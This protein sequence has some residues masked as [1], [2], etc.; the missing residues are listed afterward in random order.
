[1]FVQLNLILILW[2]YI[3]DE[4]YRIEKVRGRGGERRGE[5]RRRRRRRQTKVEFRRKEVSSFN[6]SKLRVLQCISPF[7]Y[8]VSKNLFYVGNI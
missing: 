2:R 6:S 3:D 8:K 1:M 5:S 4:Q 7:I